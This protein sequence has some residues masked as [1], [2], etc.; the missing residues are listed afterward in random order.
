MSGK[1]PKFKSA[2]GKSTDSSVGGPHRLPRADMPLPPATRQ[3]DQQLPP[4]NLDTGAAAQSV[5][6][7]A[8]LMS[9]V[10]GEIAIAASAPSFSD[11]WIPA[12]KNL[13]ESDTRSVQVFK[14]RQYVAV[15]DEYCVQVVPDTESGQFRATVASELHASG[16]LMT[17]D[18]KGKF[19]RPVNSDDP[20]SLPGME[21]RGL[22][23]KDDSDQPEA[24]R[25]IDERLARLYPTMTE[26]ARGA[27]RR[28]RLIGDSTLA[29]ARLE[30]EYFTLVKELGAWTAAVPSHHPVTGLALTDAEVAAH[31]TSRQLFAEELQANWSRQVTTA[32]P[33]TSSL[34]E[35]KLDIV[36][37]MPTLSADFSHVTEIN[38]SSSFALSGS[39][40]LGCFQGLRYL[41]LTGFALKSFP[42]EVFQM[43]A[44]K[45]L[46][47]DNCDIRL[48]EATVEGLAHIDELTLLDLSQN[49]LGLAPDVS[50]MRRLDS[51]YLSNT[52]LA[53]V[54]AGLFDLESLGYADLGN[55]KITSLPPELFDVPDVWE[56]NYNF[57]NNPLDEDTLQRITA[58]IDG[59]GLDRKVLI[60]VDGDVWVPQQN[61]VFDGV[62][63][64]LDSSGED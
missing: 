36:G 37:S 46:T 56:V 49:P 60:Q 26:E 50:F 55:N 32:N 20:V 30:A 3:P 12:L 27:M 1:P 52:G 8:G 53:E 40:F 18:A 33:Y 17:L 4:F 10:I 5:S 16:P 24:L 42:F 58:Y 2:S 25:T 63:S 57:R 19:W 54:P 59:A 45:T 35:Y 39:E 15:A 34:L 22:F 44:L 7:S 41:T 28:E 21:R 9:S 11:Y 62:D 61:V 6:V 51:L 14:Q 31:R 64:G 47:L 43:R 38:L 29:V 13:G 23:S 48:S